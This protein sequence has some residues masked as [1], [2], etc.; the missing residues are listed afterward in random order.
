MTIRILSYVSLYGSKEEEKSGKARR[1]EL[2]SRR[3]FASVRRYIQYC[4]RRIQLLVPHTTG[5]SIQFV[6]IVVLLSC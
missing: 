2:L 5:Y 6:D 4:V 3:L 1:I